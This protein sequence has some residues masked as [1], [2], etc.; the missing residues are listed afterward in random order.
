MEPSGNAIFAA[1]SRRSGA[2]G[3][4]VSAIG[5]L[6]LLFGIRDTPVLSYS[7]QLNRFTIGPAIVFHL[8]ARAGL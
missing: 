5:G 4:I 7:P 8:S 6:S 2:D 3:S 1:R